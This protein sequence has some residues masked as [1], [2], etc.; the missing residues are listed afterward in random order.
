MGVDALSNLLILV[1]S[2]CHI[3]T[4]TD[5]PM[6]SSLTLHFTAASFCF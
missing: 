3:P 4:Y 5:H 6:H 1:V 2:A